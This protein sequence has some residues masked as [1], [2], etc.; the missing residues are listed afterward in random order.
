[1]PDEQPSVEPKVKKERKAR[2]DR[3]MISFHTT[4]ALAEK[5][6]DEVEKKKQLGKKTSVSELVNEAVVDK[7]G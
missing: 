2:I 6:K 7:Y 3:R 5:L 1:M 4:P